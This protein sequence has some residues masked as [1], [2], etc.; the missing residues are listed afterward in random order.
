MLVFIFSI[1]NQKNKTKRLNNHNNLQLQDIFISTPT[2]A[3]DINDT[4]I[5]TVFKGVY[6]ENSINENILNFPQSILLET[7][8]NNTSFLIFCF[9]EAENFKQFQLFH[10][11]PLYAIVIQ[12][13][14]FVEKY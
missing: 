13:I 4:R 10:I 14:Y 5:F 8:L 2:A 3:K 7:K 11:C 9:N 1:I 6:I 12:L